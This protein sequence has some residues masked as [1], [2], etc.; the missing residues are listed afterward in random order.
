MH[1]RT[2][3]VVDSRR[4][5]S[6]RIPRPDLS[7]RIKSPNACNQCHKD[8]TIDWALSYVKKWYGPSFTEK[9]H[10]GTVLFDGRA[11][12]PGV[13]GALYGL[14]L[15]QDF[16]NI[17]RAT[18][19]DLLRSYPGREA[20][21]IIELSLTEKDP[22]IRLAA[23]NV[24]RSLDRD[25]QARLLKPMLSDAIKVVRA[26][27]ARVLA[28]LPDYMFSYN[29]RAELERVIDDYIEI[30]MAIAD[31]P[32]AHLNLGVL[33]MYRGGYDKAEAC[34]KQA[35]QLEP[36]FSLAYINLADL[37][38][39]KHQEDIAEKIM[40]DVIQRF[41]EVPELY[42]TL[43]LSLVRQQRNEEALALI[44]KAVSL[45]PS[46]A[47]LNYVYGVALNSDGK[48]DQAISVLEE[49]VKQNP[50]HRDLLYALVTIHRD[51]GEIEPAITYA[52]RLVEVA[53]NDPNVRQLFQQIQSSTPK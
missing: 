13:A 42:Y 41:P 36:D 43:G 40:R 14:I 24:A 45:R 51:R 44:E 30:Q 16:P 33:Y 50:Y 15:N 1:E 25:N 2:Y 23:V 29:E 19:I 53:P 8:K 11:G 6:I 35:I 22:L 12:K 52:Q 32:T 27:A 47:D 48:S 20:L 17:V 31:N 9:P 37:Y 3:M 28:A 4:D 46:D 7:K 26:E 10:Y 21:Q 38:R 49:A 18:A 34:Y 39:Q 5:H